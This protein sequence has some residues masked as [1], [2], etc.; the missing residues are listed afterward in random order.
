MRGSSVLSVASALIMVL[1]MVAVGFAPAAAGAGAPG[2]AINQ[3]GPAGDDD[4]GPPDH[5]G[6]PSENVEVRD[7]AGG[8]PGQGGPPAHAEAW[9]LSASS[10]GADMAAEIVLDGDRL[11][12]VVLSD[13]VNHDGREVALSLEALEE[14]V[15]ELPDRVYGV[16]ESGEEW[17]SELRVE[18]ES[19]VFDVPRFS[20][21]EVSFVGEISIEADPAEHGAEFDYVLGENESVEDLDLSITGQTNS[22][23]QTVEDPA[24][25]DGSDVDFAVEGNQETNVTVS[26]SGLSGSK[27]NPDVT[28]S[29]GIES[30]ITVADD[31]SFFVANNGT[32]TNLRETSAPENPV[33]SDL[34]IGSAFNLAI[35]DN[36]ETML[37]I[38]EDDDAVVLDISDPDNPNVVAEISAPSDDEFRSVEISGDGDTALITDFS[39]RIHSV[40]LSDQQDPSLTE[41]TTAGSNFRSLALSNNGSVGLAGNNDYKIYSFDLTDPTNPEF[42]T[43]DDSDDLVESV[44]ISDDGSKGAAAGGDIYFLDLSDPLNPTHNSFTTDRPDEI[45]ISKDGNVAISGS[46]EEAALWD[47]SDI[48]NPS[49]NIIPEVEEF[50]TSVSLSGDGSVGIVGTGGENAFVVETSDLSDPTISKF[51]NTSDHVGTAGLSDQGSIGFFG[52]NGEDEIFAVS[53]AGA[54]VDPSIDIG[55]ETV[56][57]SGELTEDDEFSETVQSVSP[58]EYSSTMSLSDGGTAVTL[59][60]TETTTAVDPSVT[61]ESDNGTES[62]SHTGELAAGETVDIADQIDQS[63]IDGNVSVG[64]SVSESFDGPIGMIN[65]SYQHEAA[66]Y[67]SISYTG[68]AFSERYSVSK[69]WDTDRDSAQL[70]VPWASDHVINVRSL[71]VDGVE[72]DEFNA[73]DGELIVELGDV[74]A[75]E[76]TTVTA[77][78]TKIQVHDGD[79][80]VLEP[81]KLGEQLSTDV[82]IDNPGPDY[83]IEV[84]ETAE[85]E[86]VHW[87]D[88]ATWSD[89]DSFARIEA[90][91]SQFL[92]MDPNDGSQATI[93]NVP[94]EADV[95]SGEAT[96]RVE[97]PGPDPGDIEF[98]IGPGESAGDSI[99]LIYYETVS[100]QTY[101]LYSVTEDRTVSTETAS[102]P[103]TFRVSDDAGTYQIIQD[104]LSSA[105][106]VV[107]DSTGDVSDTIPDW[108]L[109]IV[110]LSGSI[111]GIAAGSRR[112]GSTDEVS[113]GA[114]LVGA[115]VIGWL[116]LEFSTIDP[117]TTQFLS[118]VFGPINEFVAGFFD[119]LEAV[120]LAVVLGV[121]RGFETFVGSVV[122]GFFGGFVTGAAG[123][124]LVS[125]GVLVALLW[126]EQ[127]TDLS[128]PLP[129]WVGVGGFT[130][131]WLLETV[132]QDSV[133]GQLSQGLEDIG[134][135]IWLLLVGGGIAIIV[136]WLRSRQTQVSI[137][138][139][140]Q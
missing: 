62:A 41:I 100:D 117:L 45:A 101:S 92:E 54:A 30:I 22:K 111:V 52:S 16:H 70:R 64:V 121:F 84:G 71:E 2:D 90:D 11:D 47:V 37:A 78:G 126:L 35:D 34:G 75:G 19:V 66:D 12:R 85:G 87:I 106:S 97:D 81:T 67:R 119:L 96:F 127:T 38:N 124:L 69:I 68:E 130:G 82:Q 7:R 122:A 118:L 88:Q 103:V 23:N 120:L 109:I 51:T 44:D 73:K 57:Y 93:R 61:V 72:H 107:T 6:I 21:N 77:V 15:D 3:Q 114:V 59:D 134:P 129:A 20:T 131:I 138:G 5:A 99:D 94:V 139:E 116:V 89:E 91:G 43:V 108:L 105:T 10:H 95:L 60:W 32:H 14:G 36:S 31:A 50:V 98:Q 33:I 26:L 4:I 112:L 110:V 49:E 136:A 104:E 58:G 39:D 42:Q 27:T 25:L 125:T 48:S 1:S 79:A 113:R 53:M 80:T 28:Q 9:G 13:E 17:S 29:D 115:P 140:V 18:D 40:D 74:E 128:I 135:L 102:S 132:S 46:S 123:S 137:A 56:S 8:A 24:V 86:R 83:A 65:M 63:S 76:E 55:G 133:I